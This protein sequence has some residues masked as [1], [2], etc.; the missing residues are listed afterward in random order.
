VSEESPHASNAWSERAGELATWAWTRLVNRPDAYGQYFEVSEREREYLKP[1]GTFGKVGKAKTVKKPLTKDTLRRHFCGADQGHLIGL[2]ST[3]PSNTCMWFALDFDLKDDS[4]NP[5]KKP[6]DTPE[7]TWEA[8]LRI[9]DRL[10]ALGAYPL[11]IASNGLGGY[12]LLVLF[13]EPAPVALVFDIAQA[14][15]AG[16]G[17]QK[18]PE[19]FPKQRKLKDALSFGNWL[20]L[21]GRHH[22]HDHW[23]TVWDG[24]RLLA[25][26]EAI[27]FLLSRPP[28]DVRLLE[29]LVGGG[30]RRTGGEK[31]GAADGQR[32]AEEAPG[33]AGTEERGQ[34][35]AE[36]RAYMGRQQRELV[37][38]QGRDNAAYIHACFLVKD[39]AL[40]DEE[41][42][43]LLNAWDQDNQPPLGEAVLREKM[44]NAHR[45]GQDA[46]GHQNQHNGRALLT[47]YRTEPCVDADGKPKTRVVGLTAQTIA[48]TM[49]ALTDGWPCREGA[50]LFAVDE[51]YQVQRMGS[52]NELFGWIASQLPHAEEHP[53]DW[54]DKTPN[55][56]LRGEF[57][58]YLKKTA[59]EYKA[60]EAFP[61]EPPIEGHYYA[62][63]PTTG[64]DG[65]ALDGLLA[66]F[67]PATEADRGLL[68]A[69]L[70]TL[71]W[72]APGGKRP[73]FV[74]EAAEGDEQGGRGVG[75]TTVVHK[76]GALVG[77]VLAMEHA[78]SMDV[79]KTRLLSPAA[80]GVRLVL[81][82]NLKSLHF[83][84]AALE[85]LVTDEVISGKEMYVGEGRRPNTITYCLTVNGAC[86][87]RDFAQRAVPIRLARPRHQPNWEAELD[88]Y[89]ARNRWAIL[90]DMVAALRTKAAPL[91]GHTRWSAWEANVAA[92]VS[93]AEEFL[94]EAARRRVA[95]DND[96]AEA[97]MV[98]E[99]FA[100]QI[101][102]LDYNPD[103]V[104]CHISARLVAEWLEQ[105]LGEKQGSHSR[106]SQRLA[107]LTIAELHAGLKFKGVRG[108]DWRGA[109][110]PPDAE[111][112][113]VDEIS[114]VPS[115]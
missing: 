97:E 36:A 32:K 69:F 3:S 92:K 66:H 7:Q 2:H 43:R 71:V 81:L 63:P 18:K 94:A 101:R 30:G 59:P 83:S 62:H 42:L 4:P 35:L 93:G 47:N 20:R 24:T 46:Y 37:E 38:G 58:A 89:I 87:S 95:L 109:D 17:L 98:R 90:G 115:F 10:L 73:L 102:A 91:R 31:H 44:A 61:H 25:G 15:V 14:L 105:A 9:Y 54:K 5:R 88:D 49:Y 113:S 52:Q 53:V 67:S 111:R 56:L 48:D 106:A 96:D 110:T 77:G 99:Y 70:L 60:I 16:H 86:L 29:R 112:F 75:K 103:R 64:G 6:L 12:H 13:A 76:A 68:R 72:G 79:V 57:L 55:L 82:D 51:Q 104:H 78:S 40:P 28:S 100:R 65:G 19:T 114:P 45:Y 84:C 80:R 1:D 85:S 23:S 26:Q 39:Y 33:S 11:L 27:D 8:A 22:T 34:R 74:F 21:P 50:T 107:N 41:A 108:F